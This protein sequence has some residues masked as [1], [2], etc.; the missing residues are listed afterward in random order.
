MSLLILIDSERSIIDVNWAVGTIVGIF[1]KS[2]LNED[3]QLTGATGRQQVMLYDAICDCRNRNFMNLARS[4]AND[5][6]SVKTMAFIFF[7]RPTSASTEILD[8]SNQ[9]RI[10]SRVWG[11]Q[12][13]GFGDMS[14]QQGCK[15]HGDIWATS[16]GSRDAK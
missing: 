5:P 11:V 13:V 15:S 12:R 4:N 1:D 7:Y 16:D 9:R 2:A 3:G 14:E 10:C 8:R 6:Y